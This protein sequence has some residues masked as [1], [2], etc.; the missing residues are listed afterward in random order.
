MTLLT[1][2]E[3]QREY[4][5]G[6]DLVRRLIRDKQIP[7]VPIG[8]RKVLVPRD[9]IDAYIKRITVPAT[10]KFFSHSASRG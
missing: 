9:G 3:V 5:L 2:A 7:S 6:R 10:R 8:P 1:P 4:R